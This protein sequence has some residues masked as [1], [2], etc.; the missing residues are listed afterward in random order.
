MNAQQVTNIFSPLNWIRH[1]TK[2]SEQN[3][4]II[5]IQKKKGPYL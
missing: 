2:N 3:D 5:M 1:A 4:Q